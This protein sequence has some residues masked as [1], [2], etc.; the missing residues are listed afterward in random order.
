[1][2]TREHGDGKATSHIRRIGLQD[3]EVLVWIS[4]QTF[5]ETFAAANSKEDM[6]QYLDEAFST[7]RLAAELQD[8]DSSFHFAEQDGKVVGYLKL[9]RGKAQTEALGDHALEIERIYVPASHQGKGV[10]Q[11]L[12]AEALRQ[13]R[14]QGADRLWLGVWEKNH[15][16]I[17]FYEKHGFV[18]FGTHL[19][20]LGNDD[21]TDLLM[22]ARLEEVTW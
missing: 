18:A 19:F 14:E 8:P 9:N 15:R 22:Q 12:L 6:R 20:R 16:A 5:M 17:R 4:R 21:Q 11:V 10:A 2:T 13:A 3:L 1:M 7:E